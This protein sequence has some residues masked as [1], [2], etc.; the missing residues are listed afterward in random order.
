[1]ISLQRLMIAGELA[2]GVL[3]GFAFV[4]LYWSSSWGHSPAGR[5]MMY[6]AAVMAG[7]M[8]ALLAL[9]LG[10]R[11]PLWVFVVGY[12]LADAVVL[13]RV[14]LFY[15][16][17]RGLRVGTSMKPGDRNTDRRRETGR[18]ANGANAD[19]AEA[20]IHLGGK[21]MSLHAV[22]DPPPDPTSTE[23]AM[24]VA[25]Y[26]TLGTVATATIATLVVFGVDLTD[27]Q[28][29]A[30]VGLVGSLI[31]AAPLVSGWF[32]RRRVYA[33]ATVA[34]M[35]DETVTE[36]QQDPG[37]SALRSRWPAKGNT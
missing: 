24:K 20:E 29:A 5:H 37:P 13:H 11:V 18:G 35:I 30:L 26:T 10:L 19:S 8:G 32:T 14:W 3:A 36:T 1:M 2:I 31:A 27:Q 4:A 6:V 33:P 21:P 28:V 34:K 16:A 23:P 25:G 15:L 17:R 9:L 12:A 7:E 22:P